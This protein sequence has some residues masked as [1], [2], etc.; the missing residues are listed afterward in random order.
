MGVALR[1]R[2]AYGVDL[3]DDGVAA[4][5]GFDLGQGVRGVGEHGVASRSFRNSS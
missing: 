4:V 2:K 5:V 1:R 3:F